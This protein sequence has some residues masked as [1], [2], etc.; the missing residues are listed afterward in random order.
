MRKHTKT[1]HKHEGVD[2]WATPRQD[3]C[4]AGTHRNHK[5]AKA[6]RPIQDAASPSLGQAWLRLGL[7][8]EEV[9]RVFL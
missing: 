6:H 4:H 2:L 7:N 3:N 9:S 1:K 8:G 5:G